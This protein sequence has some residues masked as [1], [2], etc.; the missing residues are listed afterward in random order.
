MPK[1]VEYSN[2]LANQLELMGIITPAE[3]QVFLPMLLEWK[4]GAEV[5]AFYERF[6][7]YI[8]NLP[9]L[10]DS[11][12]VVEEANLMALSKLVDRILAGIE[13]Q[14]RLTILDCRV[15]DAFYGISRILRAFNL[16]RGGWEN[17]AAEINKAF[18]AGK[19]YTR[20]DRTEVLVFEGSADE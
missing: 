19:N 20:P 6:V 14:R 9:S 3:I 5:T 4:I 13:R 15:R 18:A 10:T 1:S 2:Q 16:G 7:D 11:E 8:E 17:P 12:K